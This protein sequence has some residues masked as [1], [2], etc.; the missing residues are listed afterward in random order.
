M[1]MVFFVHHNAA[2]TPMAANGTVIIII[3]GWEYDSNK[4]A[5]T[6]YIKIITIH[7]IPGGQI[8]INSR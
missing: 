5:R 1:L 6:K 7:N 2:A 3:K 8:A 4:A